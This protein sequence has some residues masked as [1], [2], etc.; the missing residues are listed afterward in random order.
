MLLLLLL[1]ILI[2]IVY[3]QFAFVSL[4]STFIITCIN[5]TNLLA[6]EIYT[7][8]NNTKEVALRDVIQIERLQQLVHIIIEM[9][10]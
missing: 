1:I 5:L 7:Y 2:V 8:E 9:Q 4:F 10:S 3:R 6:D